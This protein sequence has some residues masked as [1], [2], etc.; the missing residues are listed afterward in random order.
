M[1]MQYTYVHIVFAIDLYTSYNNTIAQEMLQ[2]FVHKF[3]INILSS[4]NLCPD[5]FRSI[6]QHVQRSAIAQYPSVCVCM[7]VCMYVWL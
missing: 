5:D 3:L 2:Y 7:Y 4:A 1:S 6:F